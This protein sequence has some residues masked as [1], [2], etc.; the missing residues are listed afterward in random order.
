MKSVI[1]FFALLL[2]AG[3]PAWATGQ[4]TGNQYTASIFEILTAKENPK[5]VIK[6]DLLTMMENRNTDTYYEATLST[7]DG[8]VRK[9]KIKVRGKFRRRICELPPLKMKFD[10][11]DLKAEGLSNMNE[12]KIVVPCKNNKESNDWIV[13]EHLAY[14]LFQN[15]TP[16]SFRSGLVEITFQDIHVESV[17]FKMQCMLLEDV[18]ELAQRLNCDEVERFGIDPDSLNTNQAAMV[19]MFNYMIGNTDWEIAGQRNVKFLRSKNDKTAKILVVPNDFD[20]SGLVNTDYSVPNSQTG[21]N[22]V[23]ERFLMANGIAF[24]DLSRASKVLALQQE[25]IY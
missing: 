21:L 3:Q 12:I 13:R 11:D 19:S 24:D 6:T 9:L 7:E 25:T 23:R 1:P 15:L 18:E 20:F 14:T 10:K 16:V 4:P 22:H 17:E 8:K 5:M 2:L